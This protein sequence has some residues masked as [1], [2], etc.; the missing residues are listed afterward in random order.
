MEYLVITYKYPNDDPNVVMF[1]EL[2]D[3]LE[4]IKNNIKDGWVSTL[5]Q[6]IPYNLEVFVATP[7]DSK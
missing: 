6:K 2:E 3:A 1:N 5:A 7:E 4:T